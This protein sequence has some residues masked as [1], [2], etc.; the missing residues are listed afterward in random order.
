MSGMGRN[1]SFI[2]VIEAHPNV[3]N[4]RHRLFV[5]AY[6]NIVHTSPYDIETN[7]QQQYSSATTVLL[8]SPEGESVGVVKTLVTNANM[9]APRKRP[10][11]V[12]HQKFTLLEELALSSPKHRYTKVAKIP[13]A[14]NNSTISKGAY[15]S[16]SHTRYPGR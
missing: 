3:V 12:P 8:S 4:R 2:S 1:I 11:T 10:P 14:N 16:H 5:P 7:S 13:L 15:R 9:D 6:C